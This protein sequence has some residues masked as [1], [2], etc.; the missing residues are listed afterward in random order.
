MDGPTSVTTVYAMDAITG[1]IKWTYDIGCYPSSGV[2]A[3]SVTARILIVP[4]DVFCRSQTGSGRF[5]A[6]DLTT[7]QLKWTRGPNP[8]GTPA[9]VDATVFVPQADP[10]TADIVSINGFTGQVNWTT[11]YGG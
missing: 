7:G 8:S 9:V 4:T 10:F 3:I 11:D 6:L 2:P 1:N 5:V